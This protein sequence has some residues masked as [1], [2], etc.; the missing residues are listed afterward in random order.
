MRAPIQIDDTTL[1]ILQS[2]TPDTLASWYCTLNANDWP[3]GLPDPEDARLAL[4]PTRLYT[5]RRWA[6]M[7]WIEA[8]VGEKIVSRCWNRETMTDAE[9]EDFWQGCHEGND[10]AKER[11][12]AGLQQRVARDRV[13]TTHRL[14]RG[15]H[16]D[17][18]AG[19]L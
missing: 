16:R 10:A 14:D 18:V 19:D 2:H 13:R 8:A 11:Y 15:F 3:E 5:S 4:S 9:F 7:Q 6:I 17:D 12:F 1:A